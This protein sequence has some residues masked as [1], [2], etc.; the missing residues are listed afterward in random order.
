[1]G[2]FVV[3]KEN[4]GHYYV[5][6]KANGG[7][8]ILNSLKYLTKTACKSRIETI[9]INATDNLKYAY[10]KTFDGKFYFILKTVLG[11]SLGY[12]KLYE[13]ADGRDD[14]IEI[15]RKIA[16]LANVVDC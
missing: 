6:L 5:T 16:P 13:T 14:A 4:D 3:M 12:S 1:M 15:L 7:R 8:I 2:I 9:R 10:K 11:E